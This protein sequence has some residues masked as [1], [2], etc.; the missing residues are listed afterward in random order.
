M[1]KT[2]TYLLDVNVLIALTWPQHVHHARASEWFDAREARWATTPITELGFVR[3]STNSK[4]V[5]EGASPAQA[6]SMLT[7]IRSIAGHRFI[8]DD[9]SFAEPAVALSQL[10]SSRQ[11][12]DV[13]L[14]DAAAAS[15]C[16]LATLDRGIEHMLAEADRRHV[17]LLPDRVD[18]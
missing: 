6:I 17:F 10:A 3:V 7:D 4:A 9:R 12:T 18:G 16:R 1:T 8:A 11:M 5:T 2:D 14:V 13:H 15:G